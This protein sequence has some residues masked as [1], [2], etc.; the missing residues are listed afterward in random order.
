MELLPQ[1]ISP[2]IWRQLSVTVEESLAESLSDWFM[3]NGALSV[4]FDD[5]GDQPLFEPPPGETP[6]WRNTRVTALFE[7]EVDAEALSLEVRRHF[8]Q[9]ILGLDSSVVEDQ[10]WERV[11]MEHFK[12]MRFG[13]RL[14]IC[15]TGF[16]PPEPAAI[17]VILD[18]GLAFGTGTHPTTALCLEWLDSLDLAGLSVLDYGCGSGILAVAALKLGARSAEGIDIDPQALTASADNARKNAVEERLTLAYPADVRGEPAAV[19]VANILAGPLV[20]LA[21]AIL[22]RLK[23]GGHLALSG[24]LAEQADQVR[25]AYAEQVDFDPVRL[26]EEWAILTGVK[27]RG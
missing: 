23:P 21:D 6:L 12:P 20:V 19:V 13:R 9:G 1:L 27:R 11:W 18:P 14:W 16:E 17:N 26:R 25:A 8:D 7:G 5:A 22:G 3:A 15:P 4:G 2:V 24:I 10:P